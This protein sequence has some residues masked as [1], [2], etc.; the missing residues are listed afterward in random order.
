MATLLPVCFS[1]TQSTCLE[2]QFG[3]FVGKVLD[4]RFSKVI[5][6]FEVAVGNGFT[7]LI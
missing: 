5:Y 1:N 7:D 6:V 4:D 3:G 2:P